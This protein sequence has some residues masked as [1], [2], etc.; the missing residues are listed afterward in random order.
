MEN[1][2]PQSPHNDN[3]EY[4]RARPHDRIGQDSNPE[5]DKKI[6]SLV[7]SFEE[8]IA[9]FKEHIANLENKINELRKTKDRA[10]SAFDEFLNVQELTDM[11]RST[12]DPA[13]IVDILANLVSKFIDYEALGIYLFS[14]A[15]SK[16]EPLGSQPVRL[17]QA[18][19]SQLEEG[20]VDW[21]ISER[22]PVIVPWT[23]SFGTV[24]KSRN[25]NL[26]I[27]PLIAGEEPLGVALMSTV[28]SADNFSSQ[29]LK[30]LY[31]AVS[32]SAVSIQNALHTREIH[33][34]KDFLS[35]LLE[36]AG[37]VIFSLD[38][39]G[40]FNYIN[41]RIEELGFKK[42]DLLDQHYRTLFKDQET[43]RRID[44]TLKHASK[45]VFDYKFSRGSVKTQQFTVNLV[46]LSGSGSRPIGALGIMRNVT[47]I[48]QLQKKLLESERLA[49]YTQT[50]ITLNHEINN[51]LTTVMGNIYLLEKDT[52]GSDDEKLTHRF[53][54]I[55]ENCQRIQ[56]VIKKL[57]KINELKTVSYLGT[58]KMVDLGDLD[59]E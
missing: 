21:V 25:K 36:N 58:T 56:Q 1:Q 18:A 23:E 52:E 32:H 51:P 33:S 34:T 57:E 53:K 30:M 31:F 12:R 14:K 49:A 26:V 38:Q 19:Q 41:P 2:E 44:S 47:E 43:I 13:Q 28:R 35:S 40:A 45:Q 5:F 48:S 59:E 9:K 10:R 3:N 6:A 22:R 37:D 50:V 7:A 42:E 24:Q 4:R 11:I 39:K 46:P 29:D 16:L 27:V 55:Q 8:R 17:Y 54:V 20:I 15:G